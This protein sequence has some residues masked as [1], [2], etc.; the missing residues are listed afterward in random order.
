MSVAFR[1][2][3]PDN[4]DE[5]VGLKVRADQPYVASNVYSIAQAK[6]FP[7]YTILAIY[8]A[9]TMVGFVMYKLDYEAKELYLGRFMIDQRYQH[10]GYGKG[11]LDLLKNIAL[12]DP[13]I[14][15]ITLSTNPDN[16]YGIKV[17]EKFGFK[18]TGILDDGEE[19]FGLDLQKTKTPE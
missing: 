7:Q 16:V 13:G 12:E 4:F 18:D 19:V 14:E 5:C 9:E 2:I 1:E 17:Y 3:T 6:I 11:A 15:K 8:H 10:K